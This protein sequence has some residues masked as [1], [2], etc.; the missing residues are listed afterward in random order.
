MYLYGMRENLSSLNYTIDFNGHEVDFSGLSHF[1][2]FFPLIW[3]TSNLDAACSEPKYISEKVNHEYL[4]SEEKRVKWIVLFHR[5][6]YK[7]VMLL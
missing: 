3:S 2:T 4:Q 1:S 6:I 7:T 5:V